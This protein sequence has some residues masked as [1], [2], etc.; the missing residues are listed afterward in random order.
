MSN[1]QKERSEQL[2]QQFMD[3]MSGYL[4]NMVA[5]QRDVERLSE[6]ARK[7][8]DVGRK[9]LQDRHNLKRFFQDR[10]WAQV[11]QMTYQSM[12]NELVDSITFEEVRQL[13]PAVMSEIVTEAAEPEAIGAKLLPTIEMPTALQVQFPMI[14]TIYDAEEVGPGNEYPVRKFGLSSQGIVRMGKFGLRVEIQEELTKFVEGFDIMAMMLR[15]AGKAM[16]RTKEKR[17]FSHLTNAG[18]VTFDN[19]SGTTLN[20]SG[21]APNGAQNGTLT[22]DDLVFMAGD[23]INNGF[24]PDLVIINGLAWSVFARVPELREFVMQNGGPLFQWPQGNGGVHP[25]GPQQPLAANWTTAPALATTYTPPQSNILGR[26]FRTAVTPYMRLV[27]DRAGGAAPLTDIIL[28]DSRY[29]GAILQMEGITT[30]E[31]NDPRID[32]RSVKFKEYYAIAPLAEGLGIRVA[33]NVAIQRGL[34]PFNVSSFQLVGAP[35]WPPQ[36]GALVI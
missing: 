23:L 30:D 13:I 9:K 15:A 18:V 29:L 8:R 17:I 4:Q 35:T 32:V 12:V 26:G 36:L 22:L 6:E 14:G 2:V 24:I 20:T 5:D 25:Q 33:R 19:L 10:E 11:N 34:D 27:G 21:V 3:S 28:A 7:R 16:I 1:A 31:F